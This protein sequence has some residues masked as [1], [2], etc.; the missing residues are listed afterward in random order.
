MF[1][2]IAVDVE[3]A[4]KKTL[5]RGRHKQQFDEHQP[6][7]NVL[8]LL[9]IIATAAGVCVYMY[10]VAV[11]VYRLEQRVE[12]MSH[13]CG[14]SARPV[15]A[16]PQS[17]ADRRRQTS[18]ASTTLTAP[19]TTTSPSSTSSPAIDEDWVEDL[20]KSSNDIDDGL[21]THG[22]PQVGSGLPDDDE[23]DYGDEDEGDEEFSGDVSSHQSHDTRQSYKLLDDRFQLNSYDKYH[24]GRS[25][26]SAVAEADDRRRH[27]HQQQ[28]QHH[29]R[30]RGG[31]RTTSGHDSTGSNP[32]DTSRQHE[33]RRDRRRPERRR[34]RSHDDAPAGQL[35]Q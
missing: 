4:K 34:Q 19:S 30:R 12:V 16:T 1:Q 7:S 26:R 31:H 6:L 17:V 13:Q 35:A 27:Q 28:Q 2:D 32:T 21:K 14:S 20:G 18:D 22:D 24:T 23:Y 11:R 9:I 15:T 33:R 5:E 3:T 8:M 10:D 25:K 29:G